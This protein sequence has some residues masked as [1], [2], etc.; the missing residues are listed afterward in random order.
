MANQRRAGLIQVSVQGEIQDAKGMFTYGFGKPKREGIV[1]K[2]GVHGFKETP[3]V[4]F[5]EGVLTDRQTLDVGALFV[6]EDLTIQLTVGNG[7]MMILK[8]GYF[9]GDGQVTTD[10][11]EIAVRWEGSSLKE[12]Q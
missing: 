4:P 10:E 7:K 2:D 6:G 3:Q 5:I 12:V 1:G 8:D 11:G 9:A